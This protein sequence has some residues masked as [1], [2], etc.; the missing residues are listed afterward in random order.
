MK[1]ISIAVFLKPNK[2]NKSGLA[3]YISQKLVEYKGHLLDFIH[4]DPSLDHRDRKYRFDVL[5]HKATDLLWDMDSEL[6]ASFLENVYQ[7]SSIVLEPLEDVRKVVLRDS[8]NSVMRE[9]VIIS[10]A[11]MGSVPHYNVVHL[12][13]VTP[14]QDKSQWNFP[15]IVKHNLA[16]AS[17]CS[18]QMIIVKSEEDFD[19]QRITNQFSDAP[20]NDG[21]NRIIIQEYVDHYPYL[22]K[23]YVFDGHVDVQVRETLSLIDS[24]GFYIFD[25][26]KALSKDVIEI[27]EK[28]RTLLVPIQL[29]SK[30]LASSLSTVSGLSMF[31]FDLIVGYDEKVYI[32]DLNYFPGYYGISE[33]KQRLMDLILRKLNIDND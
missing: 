26:Q 21:N 11:L 13:D 15:V 29:A 18:H 30:A 10:G 2:L 27:D 22:F 28:A 25:S 5:I 12:K 24:A 7:C 1:V 16:C 23:V 32:V 31:G 14:A 20:D 3:D 4:V 33:F 8:M 6:M 17:K 9:A 19:C